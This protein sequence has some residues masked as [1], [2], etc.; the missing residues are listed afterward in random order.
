MFC[1]AHR[2]DPGGRA[3]QRQLVG[4][5][6]LMT[7]ILPMELEGADDGYGLVAIDRQFD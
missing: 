7:A 6:T 2:L 5:W 3:V 4:E 1:P